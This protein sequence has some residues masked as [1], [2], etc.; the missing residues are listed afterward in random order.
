VEAHVNRFAALTERA[1]TARRGYLLAPTAQYQA[2]YERVRAEIPAA[3]NEVAVDTMDNPVQRRFVVQLRALTDERARLVEQMMAL[4][5]KGD[6]DAAVSLFKAD[7]DH[8][9]LGKVRALTQDMLDEEGRLLKLRVARDKDNASLLL[10]VVLTGGGLMAILSFGSM[11]LM[12]RYASDL[13]KTQHEVQALN[14]DLEGRVKARTAELSRA[15]DEIQRFAYIVSHDLRSPLVNVMGFTSEL[16]VSL[17][18]LNSHVAFIAEAEPGRTPR[19]VQEAVE[20]DMPEAIGFIRSS[21]RKMDGLINAILRLSREGRR[22][23]TAEP[24][25]MDAVVSG[26]I[27]NVRHRL[28]EKGA[29]AVIEGRLP[30]LSSDRLAIEQVFGNLIDNAVKYLSPKRAGAIV[31]R[32][33][34]DGGLLVYEIQDNGRGVAPGDQER[35][36]ELFRR[37]GTQD[38]AGEGIGL[39]HVRALMY[40][41]GGTITCTSEL[42]QGAT[43]RLSFPPNL[44]N[45]A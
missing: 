39:A 36:F 40:R 32:G 38:Q 8:E 33:R 5:A 20:I 34:R 24:L 29:D 19:A 3:L 4:A 2:A 21:T 44:G 10:A 9:L 35:I 45:D 16:E 27:D 37:A 11:L 30:D 43:F 1:E 42:D 18:L 31:V 28:T 23:L 7:R 17:K 13:D 6:V 25:A 22:N 12:R 26:L 14:R 15:N 41:L